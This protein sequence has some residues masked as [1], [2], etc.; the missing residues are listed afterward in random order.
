MLAGHRPSTLSRAIGVGVLVGENYRG[1]ITTSYSTGTVTGNDAVDGLVGSGLPMYSV[2]FFWD[3]ET[4]GQTD[5]V[6]GTSKT[7]AEMQTAG[8]FLE[9][10]L[11]LRRRDR[12]RH[13]RCRFRQQLRVHDL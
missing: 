12:K 4:S 2:A 3:I 11:G 13:R 7:T 5:S 6:G 8:T 1:N 9:D 10:R